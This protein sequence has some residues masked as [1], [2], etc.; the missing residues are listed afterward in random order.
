MTYLTLTSITP[1][2]LAYSLDDGN[3]RGREKYAARD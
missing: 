2:P 1:L 3:R